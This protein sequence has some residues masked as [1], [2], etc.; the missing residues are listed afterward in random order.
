MYGVWHKNQV[1]NHAQKQS[2]SMK[3]SLTAYSLFLKSSSIWGLCK[4]PKWCPYP[5]TWELKKNMVYSMLGSWGTL[6]SGIW[7]TQPSA[8]TEMVS[9]DS[10]YPKTFS[11]RK[12]QISRMLGSQVTPW[13]APWPPTACSSGSGQS[14]AYVN[15]P[16]W[17]PIAQNLG[18]KKTCLWYAQKLSYYS[19][20]SLTSYR[21]FLGFR[22][23]W[24]LWK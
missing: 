17:F 23:I 2:Y 4:G 14:E 12:K 8:P 22:C 20:C 24:G 6:V 5:K 13:T 10:P 9:K 16:K 11:L 15:G 21:L 3:C 7:V 18:L 1:S 19:K